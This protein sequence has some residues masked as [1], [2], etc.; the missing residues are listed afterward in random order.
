[1][2]K[3]FL[4]AAAFVLSLPLFA[5]INGKVKREVQ[6][7]TYSYRVETPQAVFQERDA[8]NI[9]IKAMVNVQAD[10]YV[11]VFA[12]STVAKNV[13]DAD[14]NMNERITKIKDAISAL[15]GDQ[16][17]Y[18]DM[19]SLLPAFELE[20][21]KKIFSKTT[22]NEVPI[23][24]EMRKNLHIGFKNAEDFDRILTIC[25]QNEVYELLKADYV[26]YEVEAVYDTL[27]ARTLAL[28][29]RK[30]AYY[31]GLG[32][33]I[34]DKKREITETSA[35]YYPPER[36]ETFQASM[37]NQLQYNGPVKKSIPT[38]TS[39][40]Y[41]PVAFKGFDIVRNPEIIEPVV[42]FTYN[43]KMRID[44]KEKPEPIPQQTVTQREYF[45]ISPEGNIKPIIV[46]KENN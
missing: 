23:G 43:L 10:A 33:D 18:V 6:N 24:F 41:R 15:P 21:S 17:V 28:V 30:L 19:I 29:K 26:V 14:K 2:K 13:E 36:Y 34:E 7:R 5:Q 27:R 32:I 22:Y 35:A 38:P 11:A 31:E 9:D 20:A 25:A 1:M 42:Q 3:I 39:E 4:L 12:M 16:T 44:L 45:L 46:T 37:D 8:L 40:Y